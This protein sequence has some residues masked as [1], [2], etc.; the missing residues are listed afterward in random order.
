[1]ETRYIR[2]IHFQYFAISIEELPEGDYQIPM[3]IEN[4]PK[5][6][7]PVHEQTEN[8][9]RELV[10]D[11]TSMETLKSVYES[12]KM[13]VR[14][15]LDLFLHINRTA[16]ELERY[17]LRGSCLMLDPEN[18]FKRTGSRE[19]YF[20]YDPCN[21]MKAADKLNQLARFILDHIDY[22]NRDTLELGY[23]LF[24]ESMKESVS[25]PDFTRLALG[26]MD[27]VEGEK[28][29][30]SSEGPDRN[31]PLSENEAGMIIPEEGTA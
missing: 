15:I 7:P 17:L 28:E 30:G 29:N 6:I 13:E 31:D 22:G 2:D 25:L 27:R 3:L 8:G 23:A 19:L 9:I 16:E 11:V 12:E 10:Y 14:D 26:Y 20:C 24:Q 18:I 21:S 1:M 5:G 4:S